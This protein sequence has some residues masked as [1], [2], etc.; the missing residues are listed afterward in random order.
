MYSTLRIFQSYMD[1]PNANGH[2][3]DQLCT[4]VYKYNISAGCMYNLSDIISIVDV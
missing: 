2:D 4:Q 1:Y 3:H